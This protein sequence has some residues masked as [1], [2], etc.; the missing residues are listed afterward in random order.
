MKKI[1]IIAAIGLFISSCGS[2]YYHVGT[3]TKINKK[4][5]Q[6]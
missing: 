2:T 5:Q 3:G 4:C 6:K 1:A